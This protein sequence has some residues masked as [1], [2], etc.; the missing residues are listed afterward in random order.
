VSLFTWRSSEV[1]LVFV[2]IEE[3]FTHGPVYI[4]YHKTCETQLC[5]HFWLLCIYGLTRPSREKFQS[6]GFSL[7]HN[8]TSKAEISK[9]CINL[10]SHRNKISIVGS[11]QNRDKATQYASSVVG[12]KPL[13]IRKFISLKRYLGSS[14]SPVLWDSHIENRPP[15]VEVDH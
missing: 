5:F 13:N 1:V 10:D 14:Q 3:N 7:S 11:C 15:P 8:F 12:F 6:V 4:T 9:C 2:E